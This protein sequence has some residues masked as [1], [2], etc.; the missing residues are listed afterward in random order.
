MKMKLE[1]E[2]EKEKEGKETKVRIFAAASLRD[3]RAH[4]FL[5]ALWMNLWCGLRNRHLHELLFCALFVNTLVDL[6]EPKPKL[7]QP[8]SES[9]ASC[10]RG[11]ID[12]KTLQR[13]QGS[14]EP[15]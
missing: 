4:F 8:N 13:F 7:S 3:Q 14:R 15:R 10:N 1:K 11:W 9:P 2:K 12:Y 5:G 6:K